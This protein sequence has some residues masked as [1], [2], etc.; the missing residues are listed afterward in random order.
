MRVFPAILS[1]VLASS[2]QTA[3]A[4]IFPRPTS[5]TLKVHP[6]QEQPLIRSLPVRTSKHL[7]GGLFSQSDDDNE[8]QGK[9][10][11][12][13]R[14]VDDVAAEAEAAL[15]EA[16]IALQKLNIKQAPDDADKLID[17]DEVAGADET[18]TQKIITNLATGKLAAEDATTKLIEKQNGIQDEKRKEAELERKRQD[19]ALTGG[20]INSAV[21]GVALGAIAGAALDIFFMMNGIDIDAIV[22]PV[23]LGVSLG[24]AAFGVG[25][26]DNQAGEATRS[27]VGGAVTSATTSVA[28]SVTSAVD[29]AVE[30]AK[31]IPVN[32]KTAVDKKV[33]ETKDEIKSIPDKVKDAAVGTAEGIT[34]EIK[35]IPDKVNRAALETAEEIT[36]EIKQIPDLVRDAA[37]KSAEK[38]KSEIEVATKKAV[39][40]VKATPGRV[41]QSTRETVAKTVE[42]TEKRIEKAV[43]DAVALPKKTLDDVSVHVD[44]YPNSY[45]L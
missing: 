34:G 21:G 42:D 13:K 2:S 27:I 43:E 7:P 23:A 12:E 15:K 17:V 8:P 10:K 40:E 29:S 26:Q 25:K 38:T 6:T 11:G 1:L 37:I 44:Q 36:S 39:D 24:A 9:T 32:I 30:D 22:A 33:Q 18:E 41:V 3:D 28:S 20:A 35:Q 4:F 5:T 16:E 14:A 31:A 45:F 19:D